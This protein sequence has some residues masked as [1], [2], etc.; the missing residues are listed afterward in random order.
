MNQGVTLSCIQQSA[1]WITSV[2]M[3]GMRWRGCQYWATLR[4]CTRLM[5]RRGVY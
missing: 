2:E 4:F 3:G 1:E 5:D